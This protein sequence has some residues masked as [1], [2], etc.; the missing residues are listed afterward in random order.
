MSEEML[1]LRT[2]LRQRRNVL[3]GGLQDFA[4]RRD[5]HGVHD[6]AVEIQGIEITLQMLEAQEPE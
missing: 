3:W 5:A 4:E 1:V 2:W 6:M